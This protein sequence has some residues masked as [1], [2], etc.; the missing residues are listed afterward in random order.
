MLPI[1]RQFSD[2]YPRVYGFIMFMVG[3]AFAQLGHVFH[4]RGLAWIFIIFAALFGITGIIYI[5]LGSK[6]RGWDAR[7]LAKNKSRS[8]A[9]RVALEQIA[10]MVTF[11]IVTI[12][13]Y[14]LLR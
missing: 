14:F 5:G 1:V 12:L 2:R 11:V 4:S 9:K 7:F 3:C 10:L 6:C 13:L 8:D